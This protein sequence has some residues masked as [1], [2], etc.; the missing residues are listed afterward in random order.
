MRRDFDC[1]NSEIIYHGVTQ[2]NEKRNKEEENERKN[3][4]QHT[5]IRR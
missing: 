1:L 4:L 5:G 2:R 3:F